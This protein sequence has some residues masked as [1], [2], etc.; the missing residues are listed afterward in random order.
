M[1]IG[2]TDAEKNMASIVTYLRADGEKSNL[3][4]ANNLFLAKEGRQLNSEAQAPA[5]AILSATAAELT[6]TAFGYRDE[7]DPTILKLQALSGLFRFIVIKAADIGKD[8]LKFI[9]QLTETGRSV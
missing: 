7:N 3:L 1:A 4:L 9:R 8:I 5:L 2:L 6:V